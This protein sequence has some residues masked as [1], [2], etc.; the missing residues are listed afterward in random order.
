MA[1][2]RVGRSGS[3]D[4]SLASPSTRRGIRVERVAPLSSVRGIQ[5]ASVDALTWSATLVVL[6]DMFLEKQGGAAGRAEVE[7]AKEKA[8][9]PGDAAAR[10]ARVSLKCA[11]GSLSPKGGVAVGAVD[12][13]NLRL[14]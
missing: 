11:G 2:I 14:F 10:S 6:V 12:P 13:E 3:S 1:G 4:V 9:P 7:N 5:V 8:S